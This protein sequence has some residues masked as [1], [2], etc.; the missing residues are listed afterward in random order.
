M[1]SFSGSLTRCEM[2]GAHT[3]TRRPIG[4]AVVRDEVDALEVAKDALEPGRRDPAAGVADCELERGQAAR[5]H[6]SGLAHHPYG[7]TLGVLH[8]QKHARSA[9]GML[10]KVRAPLPAFAVR[11]AT[12]VWTFLASPTTN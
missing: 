6:G 2:G 1:P 5:A 12:I 11:L 4:L 3:D 9:G 10:R 8:C 7:P